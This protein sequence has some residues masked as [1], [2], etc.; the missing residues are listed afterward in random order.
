MIRNNI[1]VYVDHITVIGNNNR[2]YGNWCTIIG[3]N[4]IVYGNYCNITG[5][6][7]TIY[8]HSCQVSG[9]NTKYAKN[10]KITNVNDIENFQS[11]FPKTQSQL[12][13]DRFNATFLKSTTAPVAATLGGIAFPNISCGKTYIRS[14]SEIRFPNSVCENTNI[15]SSVFNQNTTSSES[16]F[17]EDKNLCSICLDTRARIVFTK[18]GHLCIC[19]PCSQELPKE[20]EDNDKKCP[21]CRCI[22][23]TL[24]TYST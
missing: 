14:P 19:E 13:C 12:E 15:E 4:C 11:L 9:N 10:E 6:N 24:K 5:N 8:G 23:S 18:C 7:C 17:K 20:N 16:D 22:S 3:N 1:T 2:I 21:I